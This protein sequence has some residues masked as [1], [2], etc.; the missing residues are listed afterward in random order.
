MI[1]S[2]ILASAPV[3]DHNF[4]VKSILA[5]RLVLPLGLIFPQS[6]MTSAFKQHSLRAAFPSKKFSGFEK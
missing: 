4:I 6:G 3:P 5:L 1:V 2:S